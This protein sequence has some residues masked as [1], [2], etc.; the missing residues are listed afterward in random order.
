M[1]HNASQL[2]VSGKFV[3]FG[4]ACTK[5]KSGGADSDGLFDGADGVNREQDINRSNRA[6]WLAE[7]DEALREAERLTT[8][9]SRHPPKSRSAMLLRTRIKAARTEVVALQQ[10]ANGARFAPNT[11]PLEMWWRGTSL[12]ATDQTP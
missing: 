9:L 3:R 8:L 12:S 11:H 4:H 6:R 10:G 2:D 7:L 5:S 1:E